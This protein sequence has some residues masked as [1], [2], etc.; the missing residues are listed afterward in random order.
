M[1]LLWNSA[2][3]QAS[4]LASL[5]PIG[6]ST[7]AGFSVRPVDCTRLIRQRA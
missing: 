2:R 5:H 3:I 1:I 7:N 4:V 6:L